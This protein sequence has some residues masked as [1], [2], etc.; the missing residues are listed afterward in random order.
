MPTDLRGY[1]VADKSPDVEPQTVQAT[2]TTAVQVT[3]PSPAPIAVTASVVAPAAPVVQV[4]SHP[5]LDKLFQILTALE[6]LI[7]A[8]SLPFI[9][10]AK[11]QAVLTEEL[12]VAQAVTGAL[13]TL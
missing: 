13:G 7:F 11:T 8:G 4:V 2:A 5:A 10:N 12:P 1:F 3:A 6:P 9:K